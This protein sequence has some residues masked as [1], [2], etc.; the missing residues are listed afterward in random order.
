MTDFKKIKLLILDCDGVL[1]D[2]KIIYNDN[3]IE[4][5]NFSAKETI[6]A[7]KSGIFPQKTVWE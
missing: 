5:R 2:G 4:I 3:R 6:I 1:T 7:S